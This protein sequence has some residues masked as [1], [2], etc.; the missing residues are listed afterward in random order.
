MNDLVRRSW[1]DRVSLV[2]QDVFLFTGTIRDNLLEYKPAATDK[3]LRE[4]CNKAGALEFIDAMVH[5]LG[6]KVGERG[7]TLSGGQRQR[8]A[9][10]RALLRNSE[11]LIFDEAMSALD[12]ETEAKILKSLLM[13]SPKR[14]ILLVSHRLATVR[15][16]DHIVVLDGG[17][18]VEQG[19]HQ[20]LLERRGRYFEIF[21]TQ[22][23]LQ[24]V[25][26]SDAALG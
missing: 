23:G 13:D 6:T 10:A 14:I 24:S 5:G 12:G 9:I 17:R 19:T 22:M 26:T 18:V 16:A 25:A 1:L 11:V 2:R 4:A 8:I 3:E 20:Q 15:N 21:A 7:L